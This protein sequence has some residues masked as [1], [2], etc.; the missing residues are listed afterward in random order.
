MEKVAVDALSKRSGD[1]GSPGRLNMRKG[2]PESVNEKRIFARCWN[3]QRQA[4][5]K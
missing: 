3:E 1:S 2:T 4:E 5:V